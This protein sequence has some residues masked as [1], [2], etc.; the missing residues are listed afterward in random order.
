M[1]AVYRGF[2]DLRVSTELLYRNSAYIVIYTLNRQFF[3]KGR[4]NFD[5][6]GAIGQ[7]REFVK[8]YGRN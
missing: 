7:L 6:D 8:Q 5:I 1:T 4:T 2:L 3:S